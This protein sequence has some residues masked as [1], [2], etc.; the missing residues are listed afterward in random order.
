LSQNLAGP[1]LGDP[2]SKFVHVET[3]PSLASLVT[4]CETFKAEFSL[5]R[6][7]GSMVA[8]NE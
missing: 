3:S 2:Y 1:N 4:P 5:L 6:L 7:A 8:L